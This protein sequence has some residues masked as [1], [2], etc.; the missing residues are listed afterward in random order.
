MYGPLSH[1]DDERHITA[2]I[3]SLQTNTLFARWGVPNSG[4]DC[5]L[6]VMAVVL[7]GRKIPGNIPDCTSYKTTK[8]AAASYLS[9]ICSGRFWHLCIFVCSDFT[10][11]IFDKDLS[12]PINTFPF[13]N[14][15]YGVWPR[16]TISHLDVHAMSL[17]N[18]VRISPILKY[19]YICCLFNTLGE[20]TGI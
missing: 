8:R 7:R 1:L 2:L 3:C 17:S 4:A 18:P 13:T 11:F 15:I 20:M 9:L 5:A 19:A 6:P 16:Q 10:M 12:G 14:V